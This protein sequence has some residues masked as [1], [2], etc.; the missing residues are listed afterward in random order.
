MAELRL[1]DLW[2]ALLRRFWNANADAL[3]RHLNQMRNSKRTRATRG[4][5]TPDR[6]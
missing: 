6:R 4:K 3:E 5:R 1:L 2:L